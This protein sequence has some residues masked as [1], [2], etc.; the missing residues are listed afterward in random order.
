MLNKLLKSES[1]ENMIYDEHSDPKV[2]S[3]YEKFDKILVT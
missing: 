3:S 2:A 1:G